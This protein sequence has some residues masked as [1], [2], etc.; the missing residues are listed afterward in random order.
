M[1]R[2]QQYDLDG[3]TVCYYLD[4][5]AVADDAE[6]GKLLLLRQRR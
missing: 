6:M 4:T 5:A 2:Q 1:K 3:D